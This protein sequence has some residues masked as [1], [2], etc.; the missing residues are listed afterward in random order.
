VVLVLAFGAL[1]AATLPIAV[2]MLA[3]T[4]ALGVVA[5]AAEYTT[6]SV[7]VLTIT[8]M[9][10]LGVG[11]DYSLLVVTRFREEL[12][13]GLTPSDAAIRTIHTA[14]SAVVTSGLT[15]VVG[16]AALFTTPLYE[17]RSVAIGGLLVV[18]TAVLLAVTFLP[19]VLSILGRNIDRPRWLARV[20]A[21]IRPPDGAPGPGGWSQPG[22]HCVG[23]GVSAILTLPPRPSARPSRCQR[24]RRSRSASL[25]RS[26]G[27]SARAAIH[28]ARIE[29]PGRIG[30]GGP[31]P[32]RI[33]SLTD[34]LRRSR[35]REVIVQHPP[36]LVDAPARDV[37]R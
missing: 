34:S 1:V 17:T 2:G 23:F 28:P 22:G 9:V 35:V 36:R 21:P 37:L 14:G 27:A 31:A 24:F 19:A 26:C 8:T 25:W 5:T 15:V 10:G 16:F 29:L 20:L 12:N 3:I 30:R 4:I 18:G 11:I 33:E 13:R 32:E 6:M 7:F